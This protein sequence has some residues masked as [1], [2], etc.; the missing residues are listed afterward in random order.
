M[1]TANDRIEDL[2]I[3]WERD[4][5]LTF[6]ASKRGA[7]PPK[8]DP[9]KD[10]PRARLDEAMAERVHRVARDA[11]ER[12]GCTDPFIIYQTPGLRTHLNAQAI[13][14][15]SPFAIRLIGPVASCL[16]DAA[17][18]ALIGHE[19]GHWM[20]MGPRA[21][22]PSIIYEGWDR[23]APLDIC[24]LCTL[25]AELTA[26]RFS[27]IA[28]GGEL[29]ALVR[30]EVAIVTHDSP[31]ALGLRELDYLAELRRKVQRGEDDLFARKG[32]GYPTS[33]FRLYATWLFWKSDVH[34]E[35]TGKGPGELDLRDVDAALRTLADRGIARRPPNDD[36]TP[37]SSG[38]TTSPAVPADTARSTRA[39]VAAGR[40]ADIATSALEAGAALGGQARAAASSVASKL[41]RFVDGTEDTPVAT[42]DSAFDELERRFRALKA[43]D[44]LE[45]PAPKLRFSEDI[46]PRFRV[47][48][49]R[50]RKP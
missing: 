25:A 16:D 40:L 10:D 18:A 46:K 48:D 9:G 2:R 38:V 41:G 6:A 28:A 17:L 8:A 36:L 15:E 22:P 42:A 35:L 39:A 14:S 29:E 30:L 31:R 21:I 13:R 34:R 47:L 5:E 20:A 23:G 7:R 49:E 19:L 32:G 37:S 1:P 26:D 24:H 45:A 12:L 44:T 50:E 3:A 43:E 27:L 4:L 33:A 11:A